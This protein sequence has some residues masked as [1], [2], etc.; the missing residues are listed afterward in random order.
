[1]KYLMIKT[2]KNRKTDKKTLKSKEDLK[3]PQ[4]YEDMGKNI[5]DD[6]KEK[7]MNNPR[8]KATF[9]RSR[10]KNLS[11]AII[12]QDYYKLPKRTTRANSTIY[13]NFK[14]NSYRDVQNLNQDK[15]NIDMTLNE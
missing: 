11:I 6:L 10:H 5:L 8:I 15:A 14:P 9:E 4:K 12:S 7:V 3:N 1:M 2:L 13:R